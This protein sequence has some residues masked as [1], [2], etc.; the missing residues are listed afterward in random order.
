MVRAWLVV[1]LVGLAGLLGGC[2]AHGYVTPGRGA[3]MSLFCGPPT[4]RD[5]LTDSSVRD[6]MVKQPLASFPATL[7]VVRVQAPG[8][9]NRCLSSWG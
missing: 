6:V 5:A 2:G 4:V 7:A 8:Y 9:Q 1:G 3:Q